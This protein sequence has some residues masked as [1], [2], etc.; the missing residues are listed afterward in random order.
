[1]IGVKIMVGLN[2]EMFLGLYVRE[3]LTG[4]CEVVNGKRTPRR[5]TLDFC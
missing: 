3:I 5:L 2:L 4:T 1:M